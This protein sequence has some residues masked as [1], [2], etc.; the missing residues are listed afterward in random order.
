MDVDLDVKMKQFRFEQEPQGIR[1]QTVNF[2]EFAPQVS[3]KNA[4]YKMMRTKR[5]SYPTS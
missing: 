2:E 3:S 5:K 1:T 4:L